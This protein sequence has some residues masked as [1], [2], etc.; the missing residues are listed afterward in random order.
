MI[1]QTLRQFRIEEKIGSGAMGVVYRAVDATTGKQAA[2]KVITGEQ[3]NKSNSTPRFIREAEILQKFR[4]P[5]IVRFLGG[6]RYQ[7]QLYLAMELIRGGTIEDVLTEREFIPWEE[8]VDLGIQICSALQYAHNKGVVHRDLKPSNLLVTESGQVKLT[9]FGIAKDL[10]GTALTA[11]GR[12]LGTLAYMAP[13]QI[14]GTKEISHRTDLYALGCVLYQML[15]GKPPFEQKSQPALMNAH[16]MEPP[17]RPSGKIS[18]IPRA[19]DDLVLSLMAKN[20]AERP[21]DA[22]AVEYTLTQIRDKVQRGEKV[23]MVFGDADTPQRLGSPTRE[24]S[25]AYSNSSVESTRPRKSSKRSASAP[26]SHSWIPTRRHVEFASLILGLVAVTAGIIYVLMPPSADYL[27]RDAERLMA[28]NSPGQWALAEEHDLKELT[29]R[30]PTYKTEEIRR[31]RDKIAL[32]RAAGRARI[33]E[34][35]NFARLS[36]PKPGPET[37]YFSVYQNALE[38]SKAGLDV[39]AAAG[40]REMAKLL[41]PAKENERPWHLLAK[42]RE[43]EVNQ[44]IADRRKAAVQ[45]LDRADAMEESS[46]PTEADR[47]RES[48]VR[49]YARYQE[50]SDLLRKRAPDA[51]KARK[52]AER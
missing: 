1:G 32:E 19:L 42:Q 5:H 52:S 21:F 39:R 45:M 4:H 31:W 11:T 47:E 27:F 41:D 2:V 26:G 15:T 35:P 3:S 36:E 49:L 16:L 51:M 46:R 14:R 28:T 30:F 12:T 7:G 44:K 37:L 10:D 25:S 18:R 34:S 43:S 29:R 9:D 22:A 38:D 20:V 17:P 48:A 23:A 40:W 33:L 50:L 24:P 6:G 8:V 13:E